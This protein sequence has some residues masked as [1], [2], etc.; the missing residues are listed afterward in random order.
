MPV[1]RLYGAVDRAQ[2][3]KVDMLDVSKIKLSTAREVF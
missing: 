1:V 2:V 3:T